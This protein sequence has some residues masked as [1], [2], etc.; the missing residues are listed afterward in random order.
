MWLFEVTVLLLLAA[1]VAVGFSPKLHL[2]LELVLLIGSLLI[3]LIPGLPPLHFDSD[4]VFY[5]LMP[6]ILFAAAYFTSWNDFKRNIRPI[7]LLAVGLVLF[8]VVGIGFAVHYLFPQIPLSVACLLGAIVSPP[9]ASAATAIGRKVGLPRRMLTIIEGESLVNDASALVCYRFALGAI[10]S[11]SF[12]LV[13]A[14]GQFVIVVVGGVLVGIVVGYL[15]IWLM[16]RLKDSTAETLLSFVTSF[17]AYWCAE[18]LHFSGVISTVVAG[19]HFGRTIPAKMTAETRLEAGGAWNVL[20]LAIN[21]IVFALI[22]LQLPQILN[23]L[24][25]ETRSVILPCTLLVS[26]MVVVLRLLWIFP[27][28]HLMRL[29]PAIKRN[30]PLPPK[31]VI[32]II[33]WT[34]MRGIVSLAAALA[35]PEVLPSGEVFPYRSLILFVTYVVILVTLLVPTLTLPKLVRKFK[36]VSGNESFSEAIMARMRMTDSVLQKLG[37]L[38]QESRYA[39]TQLDHVRRRYERFRNR[40]APNLQQTG[41]F[42][43]LDQSDQQHRLLNQEVISAERKELISLRQSGQI[44][45]EVFHQLNIELDLEE[46]RVRKY[47][48]PI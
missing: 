34:G 23:Q 24:A 25:D 43:S 26:T 44:H 14:L 16:R 4:V 6:P 36:I 5:V 20:L 8:T 22:G 9:D 37:E 45:D 15:G 27:V 18:R 13:N 39:N 46:L 41:A 47:A 48:H 28:T 10:I 11:G 1:C 40:I 38:E 35:V 31:S 3:S 32:F 7:S 42:S 33:G 2:P 21:G 12:S 30:D 17:I 19:L 29:I